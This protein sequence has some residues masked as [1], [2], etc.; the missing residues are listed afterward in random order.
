MSETTA[1]I[2]LFDGF[3][4]LDAIGPYEVLQNGAQAGA[5]LETRL[6]T[7]AET[8]RVTASHGLRVEPDGILGEPDLLIVPGGGWT[9]DDEGVRAAVDD[10]RLPAA[11]GER[12][13]TGTTIASVCTGAMVLAAA[14]VLEGRPAI[15]HQVGIDDL[16]VAA[17]SVVDARV[18]DDGDV[19]TAGGVTAGIDLALWMLE[20]EFG[21]EIAAAVET[22]MEHERR[23]EVVR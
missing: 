3:D 21:A 1:E 13:E 16:E 11:V 7:L 20:R 12:S 6:V 9:T 4:E 5:P 14:G 10:G 15:T 2:V 19:L 8:D 22:E 17:G 18:V 23:G